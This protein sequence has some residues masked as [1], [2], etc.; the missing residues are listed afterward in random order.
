MNITLVR[1]AQVEER[2]KGCYNGHNNIGLSKKGEAQAKILVKKLIPIHFDAIFSSDLLRA[3]MTIKNFPHAKDIIYTDKLREKSWGKHEGLTFDEIIALG[4]VEYI[5]FLQWIRALDGEPYEDY[6]QRV[7][8]FFFTYLPSLNK[9]NI[10][11]ITHAGVIRVLLSLVR[12]ISLEEAF[13]IE[14]ENASIT[15]IEIAL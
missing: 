3:K 12:N 10:L 7:E 4:E 5:N 14:V 11:I 2:Y 15:T 1:H 6:I 9:E 13:S 8:E